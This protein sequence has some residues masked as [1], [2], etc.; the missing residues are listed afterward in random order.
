MDVCLDTPG[1]DVVVTLRTPRSDGL[2]VQTPMD[3]L[4][5]ERDRVDVSVPDHVELQFGR[6]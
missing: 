6:L 1:S 3:A 4:C 5:D 2:R